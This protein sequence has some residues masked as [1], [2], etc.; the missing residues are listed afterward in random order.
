L[1]RFIV[2]ARQ[3]LPFQEEELINAEEEGVKFMFLVT[4]TRFIGDDQGS[5][6][7]IEIVSMELGEP[8]ASGRRRPLSHQGLRKIRK[9]SHC[10]RAQ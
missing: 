9:S 2:Q 7:A 4:P 6:K 10:Y 3:E 1:R 8:D 5:V